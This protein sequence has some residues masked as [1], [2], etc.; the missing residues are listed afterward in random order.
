MGKFASDDAGIGLYGQRSKTTPLENA[1]VGIKHRLVTRLCCL[2]GGIKAVSV[3]H[4]E[5]TSTHEP[6]PGANLVAKLGLNLIK[7]FR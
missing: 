4:D 2:I 6:E 3:L 1:H 5:L 7:V